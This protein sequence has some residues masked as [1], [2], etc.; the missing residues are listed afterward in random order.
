MDIKDWE[1]AK[2]LQAHVESVISLSMSKSDATKVLSRM[3][4]KIE[5]ETKDE[6]AIRISTR[7]ELK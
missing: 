1:K 5:T 3:H 4:T 2:D 7:T 6:G